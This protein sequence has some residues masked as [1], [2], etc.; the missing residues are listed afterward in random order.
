M[1]I[2]KGKK[3]MVF[4]STDGTSY[5][6]V[7]Y[8]T[9]HTF[10]TSVS[11]SD[12]STKDNSDS[13]T[14]AGAWI[15]EDIDTYSWSVTTD[16]LFSLDSDHG[17]NIGDLTDLYL[18]GTPVFLKFQ[19]AADGEVG[20]TGWAQKDG[21][22]LSGKA[23]ISSIEISAQNGDNASFSVEFTGKGRLSKSTK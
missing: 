8:A 9:N 14:G 11:T 5:K 7:A 4:L 17:E 1:G 3:L 22:T 12:I 15:D 6:S 19:L 13:T 23:L 16:N 10:T 2:I 20:A 21:Y 18:A